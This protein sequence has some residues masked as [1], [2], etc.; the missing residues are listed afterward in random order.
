LV[1]L[2][3]DKNLEID[4]SQLEHLVDDKTAC[5][6]IQYPNFFGSIEDL[7]HAAK[8]AHAKGAL[9]VASVQEMYSLALL[10]SPGELGADIAACEAQSFGNSV[11]FGGPHVGAIACKT[12]VMRRIPGRLVGETTD[13]DGKKGYVLTLQAREQHIRREKATSNICSNEALCALAATIHLSA[14]G[15]HGLEKAAEICNKNAEYAKRKFREKNLHV[16]NDNTFNEF[17][18]QIPNAERVYAKLIEHKILPGLKIAKYYPEMKDT[19]LLAFTEMVT[20]KD[21]DYFFEKLGASL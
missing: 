5:V 12:D 3:F 4:F 14:M 15:K 2:G 21:L 13:L 6:L 1:E 9:L 18:V 7:E 11:G 8:I 16:L 19:L 17:C 20:K 10:K